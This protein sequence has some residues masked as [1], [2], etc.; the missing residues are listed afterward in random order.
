MFTRSLHFKVTAWYTLAFAAI[1][2]I[3]STIVY[4]NFKYSLIKNLD[5]LLKSK[6]ESIDDLIDSQ[7]GDRLEGASGSEFLKSVKSVVQ[8]ER[9][10]D[11]AFV[12][13]LSSRGEML[14]Y[15][16]KYTAQIIPRVVIDSALLKGD[17]QV[18]NVKSPLIGNSYEKLRVLTMP[19]LKDG[20]ITYIIQVEEYLR[21]VYVTL[22]KL[23]TVLYLFLPLALFFA[24]LIGSFLTRIALNPVGQ[25]AKTMRQITTENLQERIQIP[26]AD[27]EIRILA[28]TFNG[29][30]T[31]LE[32]TFLTQKQFIQDISHELRTP[33]TAMRGKQE[34]ALKKDRTV[35]EYESV[36]EVNLEEIDRMSH[37]V[38]DLLVLIKIEAQGTALK[39]A[40]IDLAVL[41][42]RVL[43]GIMVLAQEKHITINSSLTEGITVK[44]NDTQ[45]SRVVLN[46]LDNA[47]KYTLINGQVEIKLFKEDSL[48]KILI[49]N[50]GPGIAPHELSRIFDRFYR[51]DQS[52]NSPGFGL[53]LSIAQSIITAHQGT[54]EVES[55]L[56]KQTIFTVTL[57]LYPFAL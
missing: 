24:V 39:I 23:K 31:R 42:E 22:H 26:N 45:I 33:L 25:I 21:P 20:K 55:Q 43:N 14:D 12:Q 5:D 30:L 8:E 54:I 2:F 18:K 50:T 49:T 16:N 11:N 15:S 38:E 46:I 6:A 28:D 13:I 19:I 10:D 4:Q 3:F 57:P 51:A 17:I 35:K 56:A 32:K 34:V 1:L 53:G 41:I 9:D 40:S 37:L 7:N 29:M 36:L 44:G 48:A 27:N 52:R 47:I